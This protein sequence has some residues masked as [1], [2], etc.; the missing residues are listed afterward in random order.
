[1]NW[2]RGGPS[3]V[4][5]GPGYSAGPGASLRICGNLKEK[6]RLRSKKTATKP[7]ASTKVIRHI[8]GRI[9]LAQLPAPAAA[10]VVGVTITPIGA[11]VGGRMAS[12][13]G[14]PSAKL[15]ETWTESGF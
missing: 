9:L 14:A 5:T 15:M 10:V 1:M 12:P 2:A 11:S 8:Q 7:R 13:D 3:P 4:V 6:L